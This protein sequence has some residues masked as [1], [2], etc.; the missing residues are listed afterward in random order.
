MK[1]IEANKAAWAKL[2]E[3]HYHR[4]KKVLSE[5]PSLINRIIQDELGDV[6]GKKVIHLQCNTGA[7]TVSLSRMGAKAT[8]VDLVPLNIHYA[9]KLA[10]DFNLDTKFIESDIMT[11]KDHHQEKYDIVFTSEGVIGWLPDLNR[12]A[13]TIHHLLKDDGFFYINESHPFLMTLDE[14]A[15][16]ENKFILKYPYFDS[17]A[18]EENEIGGYASHPKEATNYF[19][20]YTLSDII[21]ALIKSGLCIEF[22]N[23]S[24]ALAWNHGG[25]QQIEEGLYQHPYFKGKFPLQFSLKATKR[26]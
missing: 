6:Q 16:N 19:W 3:D 14:K 7:D 25:M 8:G 15:L 2:A 12:W 21:N 9:K 1:E 20:M 11:L 17:T 4:F 22:F 18:D 5:R 10:E 23:E 24:D 13:E 26:K